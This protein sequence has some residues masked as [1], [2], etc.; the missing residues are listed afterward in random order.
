MVI[1]GGIKWNK[2]ENKKKKRTNQAKRSE[3]RYVLNELKRKVE[4]ETKEVKRG[5]LNKRKEN[6][7]GIVEMKNYMRERDNK[8]DESKEWNKSKTGR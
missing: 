5:R 4:K 8:D 1:K 3:G 6:T 7:I 2:C